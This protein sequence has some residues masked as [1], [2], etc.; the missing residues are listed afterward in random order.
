MVYRM[1]EECPH[2]RTPKLPQQSSRNATFRN[3]CINTE[4]FD[5]PFAGRLLLMLSAERE[6]TKLG[7]SRLIVLAGHAKPYNPVLVN[8][9]PKPLFRY[10][11]FCLT[12]A[13]FLKWNSQR[14][15]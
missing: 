14:F 2:G 4:D 8:W 6:D 15:D 13:R 3:L 10:A 1:H 11:Y 9:R 7:N 5:F 12:V